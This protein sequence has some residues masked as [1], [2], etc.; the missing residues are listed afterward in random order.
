MTRSARRLGLGLA[1]LLAAALIALGGEWAAR[2][3]TRIQR[4]SI[5]RA[6]EVHSL[7]LRGI[8]ANFN[9]LP[10][11]VAQHPDVMAALVAPDNALLRDRANRYLETVNRR[12]GSVALFVMDVNGRTRVA[13]NWNLPAELS[14]VGQSYGNRPYFRDAIAGR[15]AMFYGIGQT[16]GDPGLF[17]AAPM[18]REGM[19]LGVVAVKV[20]L[21]AIEATWA[22][23]PDPIMLADARGI[24]FLGS[25]APWLFQS[26]R[27]LAAPDLAR[28]RNDQQYGA[29]R[30][31]AAAPWAVQEVQGP[32]YR[33]Q[34]M[35]DGRTRRFLAQDAHLP[36]LG[37]TLT[38]MAD[39]APVR[40][41]R[42]LAL[43]LGSL[44]AGLAGLAA[45]YGRLQWRRLAEQR[46]ARSELEQRV[47]E[48]TAE[49]QEAH[50]FRKAMEDSL[51]VGMRARDLSGRIVYVNPALCDITGYS[52]EEL[53][54]RLPPYPYW[55][56]QDMEQ[57]WRDNDAA[58]SGQAA[59]GGFES[60][61]L[62]KDGHEVHTMIYT[63]RLIAADGRHSGWMSSVVD[64]TAQ[65]AA[66]ARQ[67]LQDRQLQHSARLASLGEMASTLAH[68]LNQ[69]LMALSNFA[70][71]A[72][73]FAEQGQQGLLVS[74]LEHISAQAQRSADIVRRIR[75]FVR[76]RTQGVE[77]CAMESVVAN[78]LALLKPEIRLQQAGVVT[79]LQQPLPAVTG[80]RVLLEQ[81][82]LNLVLNSLQAMQGLAASER[83]VEISV[84]HADCMLWLRVAD[85]G[86]GVDA[87]DAAQ[88]FQAFFTTKPDGLGLGLNI[89]RTIAE[90]HGGHLTFEHRAGGGAIFTLQ[91]P[92]K[93]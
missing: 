62:H 81:V 93:P 23:A 76:R 3:E 67:R 9:Y 53:M 25:V 47:R 74:S 28:V 80:D 92:A 15:N 12:A 79:H 16:T 38:V 58:L 20:S 37:W 27:P 24:F 64:I 75:G 33:V 2:R 49:L 7:A 51:L 84:T 41:A 56:P 69:P 48:R 44:L 17:F 77:D 59:L 18:R 42:W 21:H 31:F 29:R 50:A 52:A 30:D 90:S 11:T 8:A 14:F 72:K 34:A 73:A 60:R 26:T 13:S 86:V 6:I 82:L 63:A 46:S 4:D 1:L 10:D 65:K 32:A 39:E 89:C 66:D 83:V 19:L 78:V 61:L 88:L 40:E 87:H 91:L 85:R 45:L 5:A 70:S 43:A 35:L 36:E 55:H 68:E 22:K 54:G 71:A 57:H